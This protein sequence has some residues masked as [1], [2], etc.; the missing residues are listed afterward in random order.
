MIYSPLRI[1]FDIYSTHSISDN[2]PKASETCLVSIYSQAHF[3]NLPVGIRRNLY[4][5]YLLS[6]N[7]PERS[8][9]HLTM[10]GYWCHRGAVKTGFNDRGFNLGRRISTHLLCLLLVN[11]KI[12]GEVEDVLYGSFVFCIYASHSSADSLHIL[13]YES[14]STSAATQTYPS[15]YANS[16]CTLIF[17]YFLCLFEHFKL[18]PGGLEAQILVVHP[19][20]EYAWALE[21]EEKRCAAKYLEPR[22]ELLSDEQR[23]SNNH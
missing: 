23:S 8:F 7:L 5:F 6:L 21:V 2:I 4:Y 13:L 14:R 3:L 22:L 18:K 19:F 10:L 12:R 16:G 9:T 17:R 11:R 1:A 15:Q 20:V